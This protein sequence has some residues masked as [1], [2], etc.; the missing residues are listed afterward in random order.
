MPACV[1]LTVLFA[2]A[3]H[4]RAQP[5]DFPPIP[6]SYPALPDGLQSELYREEVYERV[7]QLT[8]YER[9]L[10]EVARPPNYRLKRGLSITATS[11]G[12][13][14]LCFGLFVGAFASAYENGQVPYFAVAG[15][16]GAMLA[17]GVTGIIVLRRQPYQ[18]EVKRVRTERAYWNRELRRLEEQRYG[19]LSAAGTLELVVGSSSA[20]LRARF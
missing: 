6:L 18:R 1:L 2:L 14:M 12:A 7:Q 3:P 15:I 16:G 9:A 10:L 20:A 11:L 19:R 4:A 8:A 13:G 5:G 17:G